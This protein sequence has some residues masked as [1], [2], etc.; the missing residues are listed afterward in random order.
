[1]EKGQEESKIWQGME[2]K[3]REKQ[4]NMV[5]NRKGVLRKGVWTGIREYGNV[6]GRFA[7][8]DQ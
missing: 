5:N 4:G 7:S 3:E 2:G 1:M 6:F 8:S